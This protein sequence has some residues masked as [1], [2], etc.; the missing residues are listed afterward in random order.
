VSKGLRFGKGKLGLSAI[1]C[2]IAVGTVGVAG[3]QGGNGGSAG[4]ASA[5]EASASANA[6]AKRKGNRMRR[7]R[8][9]RIKTPNSSRCDWFDPSV[10]LL[11]YPNNLYTKAAS[12]P[13][14]LRLSLNSASMPK[15]IGGAPIDPTEWNRN[16]GFSPGQP[17]V[18]HIP[19]LD[20]QTAF[21]NSGIVPVTDIRRYDDPGQAVVVIDAATRQRHP[22]FAEMDSRA[23]TNGE[24]HLTI[25][26]FRNF[27]EGHRYIVALRN[28]KNAGGGK[29]R[30]KNAFRVYRDRLKTR[31]RPVEK[32]RKKMEG[33]LKTLKRAGIKRKTLY[34]AWDFTVASESNLAGRVLAMRNSAF[35]QLGDTNLAN[36]TVQGTAPDVAN[37]VR[38]NF[39][40]CSAGMPACEAGED[41]ERLA[42]ITGTIEVP[43]FLTHPNSADECSPG[44]RFAYSG[45]SDLFPNFPAGQTDDVPF[46]CIIP[47]S[48]DDASGDVLP[49]RP[50]TYGHGLLGD[51][52][53]VANSVNQQFANDNNIVSCAVDWAGFAGEDVAGVIGPA[54][55]NLSLLPKTFDRTQQGFVNF[56]YLGRAM[57][58]AAGLNGEPE[59]Q[60]DFG[61]GLQPAIDTTEGLAFQG[62]SQG[63]IMGGALTALNPDFRFGA[64]DVNGM[65]YSTLL[66][67]SVD[68]DEYAT[69]LWPNYPNHEDRQ[70]I[71]SLLQQPWD[72]GEA[73][74]YAHHMTTD[75]YANT[76][77]H[78]VLMHVA[79]GDHQVSNLTAEIEAR[80]VGAR[81]VQT[82][83]K[84]GRHWESNPYFQIT[85]LTSYPFAGSAL[86]Y[87]DGGP[88]A[89]TGTVGDGTD[90]APVVNF[91]N[92]SGDDPHGYPRRSL[93]AQAQNVAFWD[94]GMVLGPCGA[95]LAP[96]P[97][98]FSNGYTGIP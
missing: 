34:L 78:R 3:A 59:F 21:N 93:D 12:T 31:Q 35:Q 41:D 45:A 75:P 18:V 9:P 5:D 24:R 38:T 28:L 11:P 22:V 8:G 52:N 40:P 60:F 13:T 7:Y 65:N 64:L 66:E 6:A 69:I 49:A 57:I 84:P 85:P 27:L 56:M 89:F 43:C 73:N 68:F 19:G 87:Y 71:L 23:P 26:P 76:P 29:I 63:G 25:R 50:A 32:R 33:I 77:S 58:H 80:T 15:N 83:L 44:A 51:L 37:L 62:I 4:S 98:C 94:T 10:C 14:G 95:L 17:I 67:R 48:I 39:L 82:A 79:Y 20:N 54:L 86:V 47:R 36:N 2:V 74:G 72:R 96:T 42:D 55:G 53:Q 1:V 92:T 61:N 88:A 46:R 70:L 30:A 90:E 97:P 91:P 81:L 16:D